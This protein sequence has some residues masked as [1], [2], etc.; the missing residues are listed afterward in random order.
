MGAFVTY[1]YTV[2]YTL[3]HI[4]PRNL[5]QT[6]SMSSYVLLIYTCE[7]TK[8]GTAWFL[9][10]LGFSFT[11]SHAKQQ[12]INKGKPKFI[13]LFSRLLCLIHFSVFCILTKSQPIIFQTVMS[14]C[15]AFSD[16][17]LLV[18]QLR[19]NDS[20]ALPTSPTPGCQ[21]EDLIVNVLYTHQ[22]AL[23]L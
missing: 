4:Y 12:V 1:V 9:F 15:V 8:T 3:I 13:S 21:I 22:S 7:H 23:K 19:I 16:E 5:M 20:V 11:A 14:L 2:V 17:C 6:C 18:W 10:K